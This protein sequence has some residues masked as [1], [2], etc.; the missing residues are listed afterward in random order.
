ML[1]RL[2]P[3]RVRGGDDQLTGLRHQRERALPQHLPASCH[4]FLWASKSRRLGQKFYGTDSSL[5]YTENTGDP[6][7]AGPRGEGVS[8]IPARAG[9]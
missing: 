3:V 5:P 7:P 8:F 9:M 1:Y 2:P 4:I 6:G